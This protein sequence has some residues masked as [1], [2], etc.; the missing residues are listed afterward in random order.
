M[1]QRPCHNFDRL[2]VAR[3]SV[4]RR[5]L[6]TAKSCG[7][8]T[9]CWC[10]IGGGAPAQPGAGKPQSADHGDKKEFVAGEITKYAVK[11]IAQGRPECFR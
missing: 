10:Q 5:S 8:G 1:L 2:H 9:R 6:R 3:R 11:T 7:P 4:W